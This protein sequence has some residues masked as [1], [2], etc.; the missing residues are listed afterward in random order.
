[1]TREELFDLKIDE[2]REDIYYEMKRVIDNLP[3]P[4]DGL[5]KFEDLVCRIGSIQHTSVPDISN[6]TLVVMCAD[7]GIL[8]EG[9]TDMG[10]YMTGLTASKLAD[11]TSSVCYMAEVA[12]VNV[13]P[14]DIG[15]NGDVNGKNLIINKIAKGTKNFLKE[16]AM[17]EDEALNAISFGI[18]LVKK[19]KN[20]G[21]G[22]ICTGDM[23]I[24]NTT[25]AVAVICAILDGDPAALTGRSTG[26]SNAL[27]KKKMD[28]I[29][30]GIKKYGY[31]RDDI[32]YD[33]F[34][35]GDPE[36][37]N[38]EAQRVFDMVLNLGGLDI[39]GLIGLYIGGAMYHVPVVVDG[40]MSAAA[41]LAADNI[42][43]GCK[44][45]MIGSHFGKEPATEIV[46]QELELDPV[47]TADMAIGEGVGAVMLMPMLDMVTN[48]YNKMSPEVEIDTDM[49]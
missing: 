24:G 32:G 22:I 23:G 15:I 17:S 4:V 35:Y 13:L 19:L 34:G 2:T 37:E 38:H 20:E 9:V 26:L 36:L 39:A 14:V 25:T 21:T 42:L 18:E 3:K 28:V 7:N 43:K 10:G 47:I 30:D 16:P 29:F 48:M 31:D 12:G 27:Y 40:I 8:E 46:F 41:A 11:G 45:Y 33:L 1:M 5:G 44:N 49:E 6:K